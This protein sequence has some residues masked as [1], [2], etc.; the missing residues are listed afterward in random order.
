MTLVQLRLANQGRGYILLAYHLRRKRCDLVRRD[1]SCIG[2]DGDVGIGVA[3]MKSWHGD[4]DHGGAGQSAI[5]NEVKRRIKCIELG[6]VDAGR[7]E[8]GGLLEKNG[9]RGWRQELDVGEVQA[10]LIHAMLSN[11]GHSHVNAA[12]LEL[13]QLGNMRT[14][15]C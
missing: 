12:R 1:E 5:G 2:L 15:S 3:N 4:A 14:W 11:L 8:V 7:M 9:I 6:R 10:G 13:V